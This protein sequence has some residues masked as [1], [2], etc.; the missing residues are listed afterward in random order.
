M[1]Y[2]MNNGLSQFQDPTG[3]IPQLPLKLQGGRNMRPPQMPPQAQPQGA[4]GITP[5]MLAMANRPA[6]AD[7]RQ[8]L[9]NYNSNVS[10]LNIGATPQA[11]P[12]MSS[13]P[14]Q[15]PVSMAP[16][17]QPP[18]DQ[19]IPPQKV[20]EVAK[21][22]PKAMASEPATQEE[23]PLHQVYLEKSASEDPLV[24]VESLDILEKASQEKPEKIHPELKQDIEQIDSE[25]KLGDLDGEAVYTCPLSNKPCSK[26]TFWQRLKEFFLHSIGMKSQEEKDAAILEFDKSDPIVK[27]YGKGTEGVTIPKPAQQPDN[28]EM[29]VRTPLMKPP[30][31]QTEQPIFNSPYGNPNLNSTPLYNPM[32]M[33]GGIA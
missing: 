31:Q 21:M 3:G 6:M 18:V 8:S 12:P 2:G 28:P 23:T 10:S 33:E 16:Q 30:V 5:E 24:K 14:V 4:P 22:M 13:P 19:G 29:G 27:K 9:E 20:E 17:A 25:Y 11:Q 1:N 32:A 26:K 7:P 15:Q